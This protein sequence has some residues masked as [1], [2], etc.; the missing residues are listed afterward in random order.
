MD[1][2]GT[3]YSSLSTLQAFR[4]DKIKIDCSFISNMESQPQAAVIVRTVVGLGRSLGIPVLAEGV[5]TETQ[6]RLLA[7]E[8]CEEAQGFLFGK[9]MALR[10]I[11]EMTRIR[12][13]QTPPVKRSAA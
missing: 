7:A 2:F 11:A 1:D 8:D 6:L 13:G 3:G 9:P 10:D 5:E 4:F 12:E